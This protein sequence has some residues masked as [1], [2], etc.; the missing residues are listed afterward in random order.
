M[1]GVLIGGEDRGTQEE[2]HVMTEAEIRVMQLQLKE[3]QGL[4]ATTRS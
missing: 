4:T 3:C 1:T 2:H